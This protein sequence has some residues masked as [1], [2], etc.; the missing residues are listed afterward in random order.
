MGCVNCKKIHGGSSV[1]VPPPRTVALGYL[2]QQ[3]G[4]AAE[5]ALKGSDS[6]A[7][8]ETQQGAAEASMSPADT[9]VAFHSPPFS[10]AGVEENAEL[11]C[12]EVV[13]TENDRTGSVHTPQKDSVVTP[14]YRLPGWPEELPVEDQTISTAAQHESQEERL[15]GGATPQLQQERQQQGQGRQQHRTKQHE[16]IVPMRSNDFYGYRRASR[17]SPPSRSKQ[18]QQQ[19]PQLQEQDQQLRDRRELSVETLSCVR[20][21]FDACVL[22]DARAAEIELK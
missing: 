22:R 5:A 12:I 8:S 16:M 21:G 6:R 3:K 13:T 2:Q 9:P 19:L 20:R 17:S 15:P 1:D 4:P 14:A 11:A 18:Q 10:V 7:G